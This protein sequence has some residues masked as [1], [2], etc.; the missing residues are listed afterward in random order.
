MT[1]LPLS[2]RCQ[3]CGMPLGEGMFGTN[4]DESLNTEY[5][6]FCF[7]NGHFTEPELTLPEM[8]ER[9]K[10]HMISELDYDEAAAGQLASDTIPH[11]KRWV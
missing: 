10:Q 2:N 11:L 3:S 6:Q 5:C 7:F 1:L 4:A 8:I 9:S